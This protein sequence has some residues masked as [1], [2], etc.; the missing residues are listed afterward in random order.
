MFRPRHIADIGKEYTSK[1][2]EEMRVRVRRFFS[3]AAR[4]A[5]LKE[6]HNA[7]YEN[8][9]RGPQKESEMEQDTRMRAVV[10]VVSKSAQA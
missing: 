8:L 1:T 6:F 7:T 2:P 10:A 3:F 4:G 9:Q 5:E